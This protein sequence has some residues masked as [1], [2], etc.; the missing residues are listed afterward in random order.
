M[1][2]KYSETKE[3]TNSNETECQHKTNVIQNNCNINQIC[4]CQQILKECNWEET[5]GEWECE[6]CHK[7]YSEDVKIY[8]W[9]GKA[10]CKY[11]Q[12]TGDKFNVCFNCFNTFDNSNDDNQSFNKHNFLSAKIAAMINII[13]K[14]I[15]K[16]KNIKQRKKYLFDVYD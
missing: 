12:I 1:T 10:I 15:N 3:K 13:N 11:K 8:Y 14:E 9:C 5:P 2:L 4:V 6:C 16:L 7:M